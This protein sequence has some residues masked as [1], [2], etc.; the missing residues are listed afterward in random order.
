MSGGRTTC[1]IRAR[2]AGRV[3]QLPRLWRT[4]GNTPISRARK[5]G[6]MRAARRRIEILRAPYAFKGRLVD[7]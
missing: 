2:V 1:L 3:R 6:A 5:T 4:R 7:G